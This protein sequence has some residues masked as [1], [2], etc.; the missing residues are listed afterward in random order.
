MKAEWG[1]EERCE[2][3]KYYSNNEEW[4]SYNAR[5]IDKDET[6]DRYEKDRY[7]REQSN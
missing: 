3:C 4:C 1:S 5:F 2:N 6:C 7:A